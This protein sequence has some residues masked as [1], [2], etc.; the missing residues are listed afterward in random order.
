MFHPFRMDIFS[1]ESI[2]FL[3][4]GEMLPQL[5]AIFRPVAAFPHLNCAEG[6]SRCPNSSEPFFPFFPYFPVGLQI[7]NANSGSAI[8]AI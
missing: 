7:K 1:L 2:P 4:P 6:F 5:I 8:V 3:P